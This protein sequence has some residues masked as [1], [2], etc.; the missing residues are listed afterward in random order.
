MEG[1]KREREEVMKGKVRG[2]GGK[3]E[4][5]RKREERKRRGLLSGKEGE[6]VEMGETV[7]RRE[8]KKVIRG[9][10]EEK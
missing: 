9:N 7:G 10:E 6:T 1:G 5:L 2:D 3:G 8:E 4:T